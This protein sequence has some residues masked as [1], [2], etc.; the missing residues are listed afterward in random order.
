MSPVAF[1]RL[2]I[3]AAIVLVAATVL[4]DVRLRGTELAPESESDSHSEPEGGYPWDKNETL[5]NGQKKQ[6]DIDSDDGQ[7]SEGRS[8]DDIQKKTEED[9]EHDVGNFSSR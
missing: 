8:N 3:L 6:H 2:L 5:K 9:R 4:Q 1:L 7:N